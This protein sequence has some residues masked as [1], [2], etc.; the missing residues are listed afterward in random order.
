MDWDIF[1]IVPTTSVPMFSSHRG[2]IVWAWTKSFEHFVKKYW[3]NKFNCIHQSTMYNYTIATIYTTVYMHSYSSISQ[4]IACMMPQQCT[5]EK[6]M[7]E[8]EKMAQHCHF[9]QRGT[10]SGGSTTCGILRWHVVHTM[11]ISMFEHIVDIAQQ[12]KTKMQLNICE[13]CYFCC[14]A[15]FE[16]GKER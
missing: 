10:S 14:F 3:A 5:I 12:V 4:S 11:L 16:A 13:K 1:K 15:A 6:M 8:I 9:S 2:R 7:H